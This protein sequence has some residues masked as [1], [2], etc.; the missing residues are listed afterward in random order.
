MIAMAQRGRG[1]F[2][3]ANSELSPKRLAHLRDRVVR[4]M[5][6]PE[7]VPIR[8]IALQL[9]PSQLEAVMKTLNIEHDT[10]DRSKNLTSQLEKA[11]LNLKAAADHKLFIA[12]CVNKARQAKAMPEYAM[13][14]N[15]Q[16][17]EMIV[18]CYY[19]QF[20]AKGMIL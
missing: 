14:T 6:D 20:I 17:A 15:S 19:P 18:I 12:T 7:G 13:M 10:V 3:M 8:T 5:V 2:L 9:T 1:T 16:V 11:K 4:G